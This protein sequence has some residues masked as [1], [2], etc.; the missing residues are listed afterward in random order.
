[1]NP[2]DRPTA[3]GID[4][5]LDGGFAALLPDRSVRLQPT[6]FLA[7]AAGMNQHEA[8]ATASCARRYPDV[9]LLMA[10]EHVSSPSIRRGRARSAPSRPEARH[11]GYSN[12]AV[13][14]HGSG[15]ARAARFDSDTTL[16]RNVPSR[17]IH[18]RQE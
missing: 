18:V 12:H 14:E 7:A 5:G 2:A 3:M 4:P 8:A 6:P 11:R 16:D 9:S 17:R 13:P 10:P 15:R 1:V